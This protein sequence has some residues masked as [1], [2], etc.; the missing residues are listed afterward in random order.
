MTGSAFWAEGF[1]LGLTTVAGTGRTVRSSRPGRPG[2]LFAPP[3]I[4]DRARLV[5]S[6]QMVWRTFVVSG[7]T[8]PVMLT[9]HPRQ[10]ASRP[11]GKTARG[12][13]DAEAY[14]FFLMVTHDRG[15][16]V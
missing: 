16:R 12:G 1:G 4:P 6:A 15:G 7:V 10:T 2:L 9:P 14:P 3:T 11:D 5:T 13:D 8:Q